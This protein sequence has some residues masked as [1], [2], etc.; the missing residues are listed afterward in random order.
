MPTVLEGLAMTELPDFIATQ[1][2]RDKQL[3]PVLTDWSLAGGALYFVT[4]TA[5]ARPAKVS[6]LADFLV[7]ELADAPWRVEIMTGSKSPV[8]RSRRA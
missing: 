2:F 6:A 5:R 3:E 4:P 1:Y 7:T 8:R